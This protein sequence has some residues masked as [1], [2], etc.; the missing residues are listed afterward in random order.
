MLNQIHIRDL[1]TIENLDLTL[2]RDSIMITG[3]TGAGKSIFIE[4]IDLALGG[5]ASPSLIR[6][7]HDKAEVSLRFDITHFPKV[8]AYL[9][10][11]DLEQEENECMIRRVITQ[12]GRS[13]CY[14]NGSPSTLQ[15]LRELG[16]LLF[17][18][19]AQHEQQLLLKL[20][21]QRELLDRYG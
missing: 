2:P 1:V 19:H 4:A 13:R 15:H 9:K 12:D 8:V 21:N 18:L 16:E 14:V 3:E 7:G 11:H 20:D 10:D 6:A 5:R 17:H